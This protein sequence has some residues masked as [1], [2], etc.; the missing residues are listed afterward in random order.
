MRCLHCQ[1]E[2]VRGSAP[3]HIDRRG[4]HLTLDSVPAW[5]C[6]QCGEPLFEDREVDA[7]QELLR[8]IE[9]RA[10]MLALAS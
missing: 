10:G 3:V 5:V 8:S 4:C 6:R 9:Q 2:L 1:G 7:I